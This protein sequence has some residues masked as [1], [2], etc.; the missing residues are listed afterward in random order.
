MDF[1]GECLFII[2]MFL[3]KSNLENDNELKFNKESSNNL[4]D[5]HKMPIILTKGDESI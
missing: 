4:F 3:A 2:Q 5:E 1:L